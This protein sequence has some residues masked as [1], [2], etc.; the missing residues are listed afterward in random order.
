MSRGLSSMG[1]WGH[2][3]FIVAC[4]LWL[5]CASTNKEKQLD[6]FRKGK[7]LLV[8]IHITHHAGTFVCWWMKYHLP[9]GAVPD[10]SCLA[11]L[12]GPVQRISTLIGLYGDAESYY[13]EPWL[14]A[15]LRGIAFEYRP[16]TKAEMYVD[17]KSAPLEDSRLVTLAVMRDPLDR[18]L[19]GDG[20]VHR[21]FGPNPSR[22]RL[23]ERK[24]TE[25]DWFHY[26]HSAY[27]NNYAL[28]I[29][30]EDVDLKY[31]VQ[32]NSS[33]AFHG[34]SDTMD[35]IDEVT[36]EMFNRAQ[37]TLSRITY[38]IDQRCLELSLQHVGINLGFDNSK[39]GYLHNA[40]HLHA[41]SRQRIANDTL[42]EELRQRNKWDIKLYEWAKT[43]AVV[44]CP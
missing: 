1:F 43:Q 17:W 36:E 6:T 11:T 2:R 41:S 33:A 21:D 29:L 25:V 37:S 39:P 44:R 7:G 18:L 4:M 30:A 27:T 12:T 22:R 40:K 3:W 13:P 9:K 10:Q 35:F 31:L 15:S 26:M 34:F 20:M 24:R 19:A 38:I 23:V 32:D 28:R 16:A 8:N 42:Y 14:N 5:S